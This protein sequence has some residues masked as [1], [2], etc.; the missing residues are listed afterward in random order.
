MSLRR[1]LVGALRDLKEL[2]IP[3]AVIGGLAVSA[4]VEPRM[5]RDVDIAVAVAD[6]AGAEEVVNK[7]VPRILPKPALP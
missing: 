7:H 2:G 4:R 3:H 6:D 5:T 1:A